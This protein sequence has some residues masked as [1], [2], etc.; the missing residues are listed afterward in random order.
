[1]ALPNLFVP[2]AAKSGTSSLHDYLGQH[3]DVFMSQ[4]KEPHFFSSN[5]NFQADHKEKLQAY[6]DLFVEGEGQRIRGESSTGYMVFPYVVERIKE[7]VPNPRFI[8]IF[9]NPIDRAYSHYWWLRGRGY[10][11][12]SFREAVL[13]D[14]HDLPD[15]NKRVTGFGA[16]R[17]YFAF[18]QYGTYLRPF[19]EAFGRE[20]MMIITT[21]QM[22]RNPLDTLNHCFTFLGVDVLD[23]LSFTR[24]NETIVYRQA[25]L[26]RFFNSMGS[27]TAFSKFL[28][29]ALPE[30]VFWAVFASRR[31]LAKSAGKVLKSEVSY[32]SI[33][34]TDRQWLRELYQGEVNLL[35]Q[36]T[37]LPYSDWQDDFP[38]NNTE[39]AV[40]EGGLQQ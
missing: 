13:A 37:R 31:F 26:F 11:T 22:K 25:N 7:I 6:T 34:Q 8:F 35:R 38:I 39:P 20:K 18:G 36:L 16:Y 33:S 29:Q 15:P 1:M 5:A 4:A 27:Q 32:S 3:P 10:E 19:I 17:F 12:R 40:V 9:R 14:M 2:G 28:R 21:K 23:D 24:T 30:K